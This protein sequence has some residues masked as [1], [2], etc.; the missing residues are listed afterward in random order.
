ML[1]RALDLFLHLCLSTC[2][3][4]CWVSMRR[5]KVLWFGLTQIIPLSICS[6][7]SRHADLPLTKKHV[8]F[9]PA[10]ARSDSEIY[11]VI[12]PEDA[13]TET[14]WFGKTRLGSSWILE[15]KKP[16]ELWCHVTGFGWSPV[17]RRRTSGGLV[18]TIKALRFTERGQELHRNMFIALFCSFTVTHVQINHTWCS[19]LIWQHRFSLACFSPLSF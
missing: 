5:N 4:E 15:I 19:N 14:R 13:E 1:I 16:R 10:S 8:H 18:Q 6:V 2:S 12:C 17:G 9:C 11:S 3:C 7:H